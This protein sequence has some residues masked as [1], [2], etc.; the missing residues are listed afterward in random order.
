MKKVAIVTGGSH[1][2]GLGHVR[3][4][5]SEG[6][7]VVATGTGSADKYRTVFDEFR[8]NGGTVTYM[9]SDVA[10]ADDRKQCVEQTIEKY[11]RIDVL[12][13]N[14]G[15]APL[16]RTDILDVSEES[17][18]RVLGINLKGAMFLTQ[19]VVKQM[20]KQEVVNSI[21]GIII[22]TGSLSSYASSVNR[23]EYC[24]SKAGVSMLTTVYA[25]RLAQE[26][27]YV[28]EVRPGVIDTDMTKVV[29]EKYSKQIAD[30]IF[31]IA[32]WGQPEDV[33]LAVSMLCEGKIKYTTGQV[34]DVDGGYHIRRL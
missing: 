16:V 5:A 6:Y 11:G 24:V 28:Y 30:G 1:G 32:R 8:N 27:I 23:V 31:P 21:R 7:A 2:I 13:N 9:Q 26:S 15:V 3:Q 20:M 10:V 33:A 4:L 25:D 14:A 34:I 29:H 18:D 19:L 12:V 17:W 22:N